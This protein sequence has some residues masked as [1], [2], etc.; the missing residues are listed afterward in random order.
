MSEGF[1]GDANMAMIF[2]RFCA[3]YKITA[4]K[5]RV[6][7]LRELVKRKKARYVRD[8]E[9]VIEGKKVLKIGFKPNNE[10]P[11]KEQK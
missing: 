9:E 11:K 2:F 3:R 5:D 4:E 1:L 8:V 7:V 10:K 6:A